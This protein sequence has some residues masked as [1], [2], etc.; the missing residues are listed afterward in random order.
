[1]VVMV[2]IIDDNPHK[3]VVKQVICRN[4]GCTLEY[5]PNDIKIF[6]STDYVGGTDVV[7]Y[8]ECPSCK[9]EVVVARN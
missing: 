7:K 3:S 1:M 5:V 6:T 2:K 8:I 4:C 9:A